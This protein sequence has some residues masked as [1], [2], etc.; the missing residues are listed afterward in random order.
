M[1]FSNILSVLAF[2]FSVIAFFHSKKSKK[3]K[4]EIKKLQNELIQKKKANLIGKIKR[5]N[6]PNSSVKYKLIIK[7]IGEAVAENVRIK[8]MENKKGIDILEKS[9]TPLDKLYPKENINLI[10][11]VSY[12]S[13]GSTSKIKIKFIWD[14]EY[15]KD[16]EE[17]RKVLIY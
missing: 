7:N 5:V 2:T 12:G 14:D 17:I 3:N 6:K 1:S 8:L 4:L 16:R 9:K 15:K 13:S 10:T 11:S